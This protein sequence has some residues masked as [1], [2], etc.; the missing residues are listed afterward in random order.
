MKMRK[1][2]TLH[3]IYFYLYLLKQNSIYS[4]LIKYYHK[5]FDNLLKTKKQI[6]LN[7][8]F[9]DILN[10]EFIEFLD[11]KMDRLEKKINKE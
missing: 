3:Q 7:I 6:S 1:W 9:K 8:S 10:N 2:Y 4:C 11:N 5:A